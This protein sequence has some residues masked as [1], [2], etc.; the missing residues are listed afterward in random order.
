MKKIIVSIAVLMVNFCFSMEMERKENNGKVKFIYKVANQALK[1][2][3]IQQNIKFYQ[4]NAPD[5]FLQ[6]I[7]EYN[8]S[9]DLIRTQFK[10]SKNNNNN[11]FLAYF[12]I[13]HDQFLLKLIK[14]T[15]TT[16][17]SLFENIE[18][19]FYLKPLFEDQ[20]QPGS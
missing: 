16:F 17:N 7:Y 15:K 4:E 11:K 10:F 1:N 18:T 13:C 6:A 19:C 3:G 14:S 2:G 20:D 8:Q 5:I 12:Y 9:L